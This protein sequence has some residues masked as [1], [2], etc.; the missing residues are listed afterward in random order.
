MFRYSV[1]PTDGGETQSRRRWGKKYRSCVCVWHNFQKLLVYRSGMFWLKSEDRFFVPN[2]GEAHE[3]A[4]NAVGQ[5]LRTNGPTSGKDLQRTDLPHNGNQNLKTRHIM[6]PNYP[7]TTFEIYFGLEN[8]CPN[9]P[10]IMCPQNYLRGGID[11]KWRTKQQR[12][13][14]E[15]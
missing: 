8:K 10:S 9:G 13:C 12:L 1:D 11:A 3:Y 14:H 6:S 15:P 4:A 2:N 5:K 7:S